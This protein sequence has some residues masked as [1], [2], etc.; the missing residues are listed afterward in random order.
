MYVYVCVCVCVGSGDKASI[1]PMLVIHG[2]ADDEVP[3]DSSA[4]FVQ[5]LEKVSGNQVKFVSIPGGT[6]CRFGL[7]NWAPEEVCVCVCV[8]VFV[9]VC[10]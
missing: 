2:S 4:R 8:C 6:H 7:R 1:P 10:V 9:C 3:H 5:L